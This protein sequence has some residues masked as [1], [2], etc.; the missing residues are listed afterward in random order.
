VVLQGVVSYKYAFDLSN[1]FSRLCTLISSSLQAT[2]LPLPYLP[3]SSPLIREFLLALFPSQAVQNGEI[4]MFDPKE[5]EFVKAGI[6]DPI[7]DGGEDGSQEE[8]GEW[9][10]KEKHSLFR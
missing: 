4:T 10:W 1:A 5:D 6:L 8:E 2:Y 7:G 3:P 9:E